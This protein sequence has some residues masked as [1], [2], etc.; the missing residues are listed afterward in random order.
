MPDHPCESSLAASPDEMVKLLR[1]ACGLLVNLKKN[2][3]LPRECIS[4]D[5]VAAIC[6]VSLRSVRTWDTSGLI[7]A[8]VRIGGRNLW[9]VRELRA[10]LAAGAPS[11]ED[12]ERRKAERRRLRQSRKR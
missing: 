10:W 12:W 9:S 1:L 8:P 6:G 11:R 2:P 5:E 4:A 3:S 7:P